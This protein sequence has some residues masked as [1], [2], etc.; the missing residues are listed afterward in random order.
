MFFKKKCPTCGAKNPKDAITCASC[1]APFELRQAEGQIAI[2]DYDEAIRLNPK[3]ADAYFS[4]GT[5]YFGLE[6]HERAI[7]DF[8]EAIRLNPKDAYYYYNRGLTYEEQGKK[9]EAITDF[10]KVITLTDDPEQVE[11]ARCEIEELS[12]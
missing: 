7:K 8:N 11:M 3:D 2:K 12:K 5:T 6:Q 9:A 4:R 1:S 10:E